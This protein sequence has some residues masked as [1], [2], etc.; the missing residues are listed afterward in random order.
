VAEGG[1]LLNRYTGITRIVGSNPIPSAIIFTP[2]MIRDLRLGLLA[3]LAVLVPGLL[4][5][6]LGLPDVVTVI[7]VMTIGVT[8]VVTLGRRWH[9]QATAARLQ[10][11]T[12]LR[13]VV[14]LA[15]TAGGMPIYWTEHAI[16]PET[17]TLVL[18][19][20]AGLGL[21]RVLELGSGLSTLTIAR[22]FQRAGAG[23]VMSFDGGKPQARRS[24]HAGRG[25]GRAAQGDFFGRAAVALVRPAEDGSADPL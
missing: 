17:V 7:V 13:S 16:T 22:A 3:G 24:R 5:F 1:G 14:G 25:P 18:Q 10:Q 8:V 15:A 23:Q 11:T 20:M 21:T 2:D 6:L 19:L 4:F 12:H 9:R